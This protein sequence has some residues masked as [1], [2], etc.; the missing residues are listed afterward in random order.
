MQNTYLFRKKAIIPPEARNRSETFWNLWECQAMHEEVAKQRFKE[1]CFNRTESLEYWTNEYNTWVADGSIIKIIFAK[2][3]ATAPA[4]IK[5]PID[6]LEGNPYGEAATIRTPRVS[7]PRL[8]GNKLTLAGLNKL[9][10][11][12]RIT[13][14]IGGAN[15]VIKMTN[16]AKSVTL[17][18]NKVGAWTKE[19][20]IAEARKLEEIK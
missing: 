13:T 5:D 19:Q 17:P 6:E 20:Y 8:E 12:Q 10:F 18:I 15:G 7:T 11:E 2:K 1:F 4:R 14:K 16:G 9:F 3:T